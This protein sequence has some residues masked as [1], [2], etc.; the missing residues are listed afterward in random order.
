MWLIGCDKSLLSTKGSWIP[1]TLRSW[2]WFSYRT[3]TRRVQW[4]CGLF[5]KPV[6]TWLFLSQ[7][8][9]SFVVANSLFQTLALCWI[10][11]GQCSRSHVGIVHGHHKYPCASRGIQTVHAELPTRKSFNQSL[12]Y[13][14]AYRLG[15]A[16]PTGHKVMK[17]EPHARFNDGILTI[18]V[19]D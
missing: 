7:S 4:A 18:H 17:A 5:C 2:T 16:L 10:K 15:H 9:I 11:R 12:S 6:E 13:V 3:D 1:F 8:I 19:L 14:K